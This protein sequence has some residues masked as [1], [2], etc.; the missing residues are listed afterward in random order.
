MSETT[1]APAPAKPAHVLTL[2]V[3]RAGEVVTVC[4]H[5]RLVAGVDRFLY[6][7]VSKLIPGAKRIVL[8]L[9]AVEHMDSLGLGALV[10][11]Y[12]ST[13]SAGVELVLIHLGTQVRRLLGLTNLLAVFTEVG[14]KGIKLH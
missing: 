11:L 13:K 2:D 6:T 9:K 7:E 3:V 14:E 1:P 4:C 10:R 5:G 8:D 12:V